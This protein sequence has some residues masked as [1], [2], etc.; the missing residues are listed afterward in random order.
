[1]PYDYT[2]YLPYRVAIGHNVAAIDMDVILQQPQV[3]PV[4][5]VERHY[6]VGGAHYDEGL[7][8]VYHFGFIESPGAY[9]NILGQFGLTDDDYCLVT[10]YAK[11]YRLAWRRYN[12]ISRLPEPGSDAKWDNFFWRNIDIYVTDMV[13]IGV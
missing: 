12:G 10:V 1:M 5:P 11:D 6:G 2:S 4:G 9:A 8:T 13:E 3:N 7:F